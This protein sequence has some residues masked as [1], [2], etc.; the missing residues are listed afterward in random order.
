MSEWK[1]IHG[2]LSFVWEW[3]WTWT[4]QHG[5]GRILSE[6]EPAFSCSF[7][8]S[9]DLDQLS[10]LSEIL[11]SNDHVETGTQSRPFPSSSW[12]TFSPL[13]KTSREAS[14]QHSLGSFML[15]SRQVTC[16]LLPP[17]GCEFLPETSVLFCLVAPGIPEA[18]RNIL[19]AG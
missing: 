16:Q 2:S 11:G 3:A 18:W 10:A 19:S 14:H 4:A 13:W 7:W 8:E 1:R 5:I 17:G 6:T 12:L 15:F 9:W